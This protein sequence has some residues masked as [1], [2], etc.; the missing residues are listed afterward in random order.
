MQVLCQTHDG[1]E[2]GSFEWVQGRDFNRA[3]DFAH[4][5]SPKD[6]KNPLEEP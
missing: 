6:S 5:S 4:R 2:Q 1:F 3:H